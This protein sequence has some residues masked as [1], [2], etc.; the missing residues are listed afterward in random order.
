MNASLTLCLDTS[1]GVAVALLHEGETVATRRSDQR[2]RHVETLTPM[3]ADCLAQAG[4]TPA[5]VARVAVGTGPAP[6]TGLRVGLV[7]AR[8][9]AQARQI[10]IDG[11]SSLEAIAAAVI[12]PGDD[13]LVVTDARRREVYWGRY[14]STEQ[15]IE[16]VA[17]PAV[18]APAQ[19]AGDHADLISGGAVVGAGVGLYPQYLAGGR[20]DE[21]QARA[22]EAHVVDPSVLGRIALRRTQAGLEQPVRALYLRLPDVQTPQGRKRAS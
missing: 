21:G 12:R 6:F 1:D 2:R 5:Q 13:V 10:P 7:T 18:A 16:T 15:D 14:R 20:S 9:F 8:A 19:V 4:A 11:V 17:G 22:A 3:I